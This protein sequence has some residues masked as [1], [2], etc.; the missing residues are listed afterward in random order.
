MDIRDLGR[1]QIREVWN[2][3]WKVEDLGERDGIDGERGIAWDS[4][5]KLVNQSGG[6][7]KI[8]K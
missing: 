8:R 6:K 4:R 5:E 7:D 3:M 1:L 2:G